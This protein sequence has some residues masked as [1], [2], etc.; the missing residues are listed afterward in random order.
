MHVDHDAENPE[1]LRSSNIVS[2][3]AD[4]GA[5]LWIGTESGLDVRE[6]DGRIVHVD[7]PPLDQRKGAR[8]RVGVRAGATTAACSSARSKGLFR[9]G[10]NLRY[11]GEIA[12]AATPPL[13]IISL[14]R[15]AAGE[16]WIGT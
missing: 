12:A 10:A 14:A 16:I 8:D 6:G 9:V 3:R 15:G 4:Q 5:R 1:S 11:L 13:S 7:I 2:L